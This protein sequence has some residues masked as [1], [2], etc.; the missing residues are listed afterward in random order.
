MDLA[1]LWRLAAGWYEGRLDQ[2][3]V[4]REPAAA[5]DYFR[6]AGLQGSFWGL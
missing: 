5:A 6:D 3:Y 4:R 1:T 2:G